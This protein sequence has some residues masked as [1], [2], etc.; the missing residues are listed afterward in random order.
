MKLCYILCYALIVVEGA[1]PVAVVSS[2]VS[3]VTSFDPSD[4]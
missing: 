3:P 2:S 1:S 4:S